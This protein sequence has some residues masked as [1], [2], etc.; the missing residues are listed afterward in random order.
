MLPAHLAA[1]I[2]QQILYYLQSTFDFRDATVEQ[3][4][5][6]FLLHPESGLFKGPWVQLQRPFRLAP[7]GVEL[8]FD[9]PVPFPPFLHQYRAWRRLA[10]RDRTPQ[11]TIIT[12]G[13]GSGKTECFLYPILDHCLRARRRGDQ[14]IKAIVLY[15]MN[16]LAADQERRFAATIYQDRQL[17]NAAI[18]VGIYTG[19]YDPAD[20]AA[21]L[22]SGTRAMGPDHGISNH[23][24]QQE[25]PPDILLTNYKMLDFLLLRPADQG[26]WRHNRPGQLRYLVMDELHTYDGA[27]GA[28]VACLIRRLKERLEIARGQLCM[29]GTSATL[30]TRQ[31]LHGAHDAAADAG[32]SSSDRLARFASTLFEEEIPADAVIGEER[33]SVA[34]IVSSDAA[35]VELPPAADCAPLEDEDASAYARRQSRLWGGPVHERL[36]TGASE[37]EQELHEKEW[38]LALGAWL[39]GLRIFRYLLEASA[40][41]VRQYLAFCFDAGVKAEQLND[42]PASGR[43]LIEDLD[44]AGGHLPQL[45][46]WVAGRES[47]LRNAF[48]D[49]FSADIQADTRQRFLDETGAELLRQRMQAAA[50]EHDRSRNEL[51]N[52]RRRLREQLKALDD[53]ET[54]AREEIEALDQIRPISLIQSVLE[55]RFVDKLKAHV[56]EQNGRWDKNLIKGAEG[57]RFSMPGS[58]QVWELELQPRLGL[59]HGVEIASQPDFLLRCDDDQVKPVAIFTDGFE[60]HCHPNNRLADDMAKRRAIIA[61]GAI[62]VW[63][64]TWEDLDDSDDLLVCPV[65]LVAPLRSLAGSWQGD[66]KVT[67]APEAIAGN[68]FRQLI[69]YIAAPYRETWAE[70]ARF[71]AFWPLQ[72]IAT[73]RRTATTALHQALSAWR[74]G[75]PL[76]IPE[77]DEDGD[78]VV[79]SKTAQERDD[80]AA[81][82]GFADIVANQPSRGID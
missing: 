11:P 80:L 61:S 38:T 9:I 68:G 39:K 3:A 69:A 76:L 59:A 22:D 43:Q 75:T 10:S 58:E 21:A 70:M 7:E 41:L 49:R 8:P 24:A 25:S 55:K 6:E 52:A 64:I 23:A 51:D 71:I 30:D 26:L 18:R 57:F 54:E 62:L 29:V 42:L 65:Q 14:G 27:Q 45:M 4:F 53:D 16:A 63:S 72:A 60:Y 32:E 1:N 31:P 13:T 78:W 67:P 56:E 47:E 2:R 48:L 20:P 79:S 17:R 34:E 28:D 36:P 35:E 37:E 66:G 50:R 15:P 5:E 46:A 33:L 81:F 82:I 74:G 77:H 40:V 44:D 73:R 12:T 19:R